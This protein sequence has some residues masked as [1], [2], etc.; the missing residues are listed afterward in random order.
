VSDLNDD[1]LERYA[2]HIVLPQI[3]G[4]GQ[5][6]LKA[7]RILV[8]GAGGIGSALIPALAGSGIGRLTIIDDDVV[9]RSN[10]Q[11][12]WMFRDDQTGMSKAQ[13]AAN[14]A[15]AINPAT[16]A[17][18]IT[19]RIDASN[20][21][22]LL[23]GHDLIVDGSDNFATRLVV[24]DTSTRLRIPLIAAAAAQ[25][26]AQVGMFRGW[27]DDEPCYRC[28]VGDAFDNDECDNCA[29]RGVLGAV[30]AIAGSF[31]ALLAIRQIAGFED[32]AAGKLFLFD[33]L[34]LNFRR[35]TIP[36]DRACKACGGSHAQSS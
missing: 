29:E 36:K 6:R 13:L 24:S 26:Q 15:M 33:G 16:D 19:T 22:E 17:H 32:E 35:I 18:P 2:R 12:Q 30:S 34:S 5:R 11:R 21:R 9:D 20:A 7:A 31:A 1:E 14:F 28:F 3:G 23:A 8:V 27:Q 10:L 4:L 25:F